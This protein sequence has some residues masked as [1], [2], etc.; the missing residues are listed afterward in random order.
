LLELRYLRHLPDE[1]AD[2]AC[3]LAIGG[4][5]SRDLYSDHDEAIFDATRPLMLSAM[6]DL[7]PRGPTFSI[8]L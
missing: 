8:A 3:R 1:L 5:G 6:P 7:A 4:F 2:A